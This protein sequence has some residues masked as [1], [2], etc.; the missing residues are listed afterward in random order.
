MFNNITFGEA[1]NIKYAKMFLLEGEITDDIFN[2]SSFTITGSSTMGDSDPTK[3][4]DSVFLQL[5]GKFK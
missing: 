4:A 3:T 1:C 5:S 2:I